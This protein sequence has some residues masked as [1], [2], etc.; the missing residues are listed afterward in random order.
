MPRHGIDL[1]FHGQHSDKNLRPSLDRIDS[2]GHYVES[3]L[4]VVC[5]F[6]NFW[7][8]DKSLFT[9]RASPITSV[10]ATGS[11]ATGRWAR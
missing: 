5:Q 11:G 3:N 7:K 4:Q 10:Q 9:K 2:E 6:I 1:Q 8:S